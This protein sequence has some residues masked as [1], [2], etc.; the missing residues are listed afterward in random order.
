VI[1][2]RVEQGALSPD[3]ES[4]KEA[5]AVA[6]EIMRG[7]G[8]DR[9][10]LAA[11]KTVLEYTKRKPTVKVDQRIGAAEELLAAVLKDAG[12]P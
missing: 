7:T 9:E 11:A 12:A 2:T 1:D 3:D 10:R 6:V 4:A 8:A 5:M